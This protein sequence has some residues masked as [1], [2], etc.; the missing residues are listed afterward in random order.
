MTDYVV[1]IMASR[2]SVLYTGVTNNIYRRLLEHRNKNGSAFTSK[3]N[4]DRLVYYEVADDPYSAICRE[5]MIK[6]WRRDKKL[7]MIRTINP[8]LKDLS[9]E[10]GGHEFERLNLKPIIMHR[11]SSPDCHRGQNDRGKGI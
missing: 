10:I 7:K 11:D 1:Y 3:Y 8:E 6:G 4:V 2:S 9:S 5:K